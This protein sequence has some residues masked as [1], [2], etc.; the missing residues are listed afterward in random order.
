[1]HPI[2]SPAA[3]GFDFPVTF[4]LT[5]M[6]SSPLSMLDYARLEIKRTGVDGSTPAKD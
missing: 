1:M 2:A 3:I 5:T 4:L 6:S